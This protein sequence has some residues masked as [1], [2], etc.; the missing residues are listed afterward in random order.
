[1]MR[2]LVM[3]AVVLTGMASDWGVRKAAASVEGN[4]YDVTV[5][6][7]F[8]TILDDVFQFETGGAFLTLDGVGT[9]NEVDL[10]VLSV[11]QADFTVNETATSY[12][13]L[14]FASFV[15]GT[16]LN[17]SGVTSVAFGFQQPE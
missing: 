17:T 13:G 1:M 11:W 14:Q 6:T 2:A 10:I 5:I 7:S 3:L 9:W 15:F 12:R 8:D 16:G 4:V